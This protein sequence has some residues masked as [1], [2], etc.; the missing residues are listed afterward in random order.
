MGRTKLNW[1]NNLLSQNGKSN[2]ERWQTEQGFSAPT[3]G[4]YWPRHE[5]RWTMME[6]M[7]FEQYNLPKEHNYIWYTKVGFWAY[8]MWLENNDGSL[9][10][11][12]AL[13]RV[14]SEELY[15]KTFAQAYDF[16]PVGNNLYIGS[17]FNG[18]GGSL[19]AFMSCGMPNGY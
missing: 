6:L 7:I 19:A 9:N 12:A 16:G 14:W 17:L 2:I 5:G 11:A 13:V 10:P 15:G 4:V 18:P 1:L 8:P 3:W